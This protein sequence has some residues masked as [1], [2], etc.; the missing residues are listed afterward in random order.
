MMR[1]IMVVACSF[2]LLGNCIS[3]STLDQATDQELREQ[4]VA[5]ATEIAQL[6]ARLRTPQPTKIPQAE[7]KTMPTRVATPMPTATIEPKGPGT[8][9]SPIPV[10]QWHTVAPSVEI[11]LLSLRITDTYQFYTLKEQ[12]PAGS[13]Y[14][15]LQ[16]EGRFMG[17]PGESFIFD[18][19][20]WFGLNTERQLM[21]TV[22][23]PD[24][25]TSFFHTVFGG[26]TTNGE[27]P[28]VGTGLTGVFYQS[29]NDERSR[30]WFVLP[31]V[32]P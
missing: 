14:Y 8:Y 26:G 9:G 3:C 18:Q 2:V 31:E 17:K 6:K 12:A 5:Q 22:D 25:E 7:I 24:P 16:V 23:A 27:V 21:R 13:H 11:R 15:L 10:G 1:R 4:V 28:F 20:D 19:F 30:V 29:S 32:K